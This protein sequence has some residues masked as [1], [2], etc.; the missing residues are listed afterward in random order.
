MTIASAAVTS[1]V[2]V[3][4]SFAVRP[5]ATERTVDVPK[6]AAAAAVIRMKIGVAFA[7]VVATTA[8]YVIM[9]VVITAV[10]IVQR[11]TT[12]VGVVYVVVILQIPAETS[13]QTSA[14]A[15][16]ATA[17]ASATTEN[18]RTA[19]IKESKENVE[20]C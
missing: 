19:K 14:S 17:T 11:C 5:S 13:R 16:A 7:A 3:A 18:Y 20:M 9:L 6:V 10:V 1:A 15:S 12:T 4:V 8:A 2:V